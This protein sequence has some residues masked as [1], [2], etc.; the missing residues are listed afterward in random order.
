MIKFF[1]LVNKVGQTRLA[2]YYEFLDA[3]ERVLLEGECVR[4]CLGVKDTSSNV[5][6]LRQYK[7]I[8]RRYASLYFIA[9]LDIDG[10]DNEMAIFEFIHCYV[11]T[12]NAV[13]GNVCEIDIMYN[14][15]RSHFILD[16]MIANGEV[17]DTNRQNITRP[18]TLMEKARNKC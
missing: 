2:K 3:N 18:L 5:V 17:V 7:L 1:L 9:G 10:D 14:L 8:F 15:D 11:E 13:F 16:E 6:E 12:L 4:K